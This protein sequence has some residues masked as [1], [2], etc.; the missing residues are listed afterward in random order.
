MQKW[1]ENSYVDIPKK[2][3]IE[4]QGFLFPEMVFQQLSLLVSFPLILKPEMLRAVL[5]KF[6]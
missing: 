3:E 2:E 5:F 1:L 6:I 4:K